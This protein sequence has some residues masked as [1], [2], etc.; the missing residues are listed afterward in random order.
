MPRQP[1]LLPRSK[2]P[3]IAIAD[4]HRL[5][6]IAD[7]LDWDELQQRVQEI[8]L[9]KLKNG[10][11]QPPHLRATLGGCAKSAKTP[12]PAIE[13]ITIWKVTPRFRYSS[14][15]FPLSKSNVTT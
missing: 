9:A 13:E 5:V 7:T 14:S 6:Q 12:W 11:G 4:T 3:T 2:T 15:F 1:E 8:R 10:A